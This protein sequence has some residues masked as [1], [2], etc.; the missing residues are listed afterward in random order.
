VIISHVYRW[1]DV[2]TVVRWSVSW[3]KSLNIPFCIFDSFRSYRY[4]FELESSFDQTVK[5]K[6]KQ[7]WSTLLPILTTRTDSTHEAS[8][9]TRHSA[10]WRNSSLTR[11]SCRPTTGSDP[12]SPRFDNTEDK[13]LTISPDL[14]LKVVPYTSGKIWSA[15]LFFSFFWQCVW[16]YPLQ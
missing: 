13:L 7:V 12:L 2:L 15:R 6:L 16:I 3:R 4:V 5:R 10:Y 9:T 11:R 1:V 8:S 14:P